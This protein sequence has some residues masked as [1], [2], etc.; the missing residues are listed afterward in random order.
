[1]TYELVL[2]PTAADQL[3]D[4][5]KR[6]QR[7]V[8]ARLERLAAHPNAGDTRAL[9]GGLKGISRLRVG[10]YRVAF[11]FDQQTRELVAIA[12]GHR[13]T[14]YDDLARRQSEE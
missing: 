11:Q 13:R 10:D 5:P 1:M 14:F 8:V 2:L 12:I 9:T 3:A 6:I 7:Q 4:L